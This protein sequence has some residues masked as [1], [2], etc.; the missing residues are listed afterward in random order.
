[1]IGGNDELV[2]VAGPWLV[3]S[4]TKILVTLFLSFLVFKHSE[5]RL[6]ISLSENES[7]LPLAPS[8]RYWS[9]PLWHLSLEIA[10][11]DKNQ[12]I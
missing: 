8:A 12:S 6:S 5:Y 3:G 2:L 4:I 9:Q 10:N 11:L 7:I 1:M